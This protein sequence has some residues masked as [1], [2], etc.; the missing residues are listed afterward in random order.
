MHIF[1][2]IKIKAAEND[3]ISLAHICRNRL[4]LIVLI[5]I[6]FQNCIPISWNYAKLPKTEEKNPFASGLSVCYI[7]EIGY[8]KESLPKISPI[9]AKEQK[10]KDSSFNDEYIFSNAKIE[11]F[12]LSEASY[13]QTVQHL[14]ERNIKVNTYQKII[15]PEILR[16]HITSAKIRELKSTVEKKPEFFLETLQKIL[17]Q[18]SESCTVK[19]TEKGS[20][21]TGK[22]CN[23]L[24]NSYFSIKL[25]ENLVQSVKFPLLEESGKLSKTQ[26]QYSLI[27][28]YEPESKREISKTVWAKI[29]LHA[30]TFGVFPYWD[31]DSRILHLLIQKGTSEENLQSIEIEIGWKRAVSIFFL[32]TF[33]LLNKRIKLTNTELAERE[34]NF[35]KEFLSDLSL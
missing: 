9:S 20:I 25:F 32:P 30:V 12:G 27:F 22:D 21:F 33:M 16:P 5:L 34:S 3:F 8:Q 7:R 17:K 4:R 10:S 2:R 24:M 18:Y 15:V 19:E 23:A 31:S 26:C 11:D 1:Q 13:L 35:L 14:Q 28:R 29:A 6:I